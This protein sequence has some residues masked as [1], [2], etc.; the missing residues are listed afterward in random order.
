YY[1][2]GEMAGE[3]A[4]EINNYLAVLSGNLELLPLFWARQDEEKFRQKLAVMKQTVDKIARFSEALPESDPDTAVFEMTDLNQLVQNTVSFLKPQNKF[5][6]IEMTTS[7]RPD[8]P[9][10]EV[11]AGQ[12]NQVLVNI[13]TNSAEALKERDSPKRISVTISPAG[14]APLLKVQIEI[15]D[16]GPGVLPDKEGLLFAKRFTT[17]R[18]GTGIGLITCR[19]I[20]EAHGGS[21]EY[22]FADGAVFRIELP[23]RQNHRELPFDATAESHDLV[24]PAEVFVGDAG[25]P[26]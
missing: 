7:L 5:D 19:K 3:V 26:A 18:K 6:K 15:V 21:I 4:H 25:A 10:V 1:T 2:R 20:V 9:W 13:L 12:I 11:D 16:N 14:A 22:R 23:L 17:R 24:Q 8:L